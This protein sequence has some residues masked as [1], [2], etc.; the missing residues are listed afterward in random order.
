VADA[1]V[2]DEAVEAVVVDGRLDDGLERLGLRDVEFVEDG[3]AARVL[4]GVDRLAAAV[5]VDVRRD[6]EPALFGDRDGGRATDSRPGAGD[7]HRIVLEAHT[8]SMVAPLIK[9]S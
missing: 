2:V 3:V 1:G 9:A 4:D 8:R 6:D 5:L 7:E